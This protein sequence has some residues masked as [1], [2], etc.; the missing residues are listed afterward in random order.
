MPLRGGER[1]GNPESGNWQDRC[2]QCATGQVVMEEVVLRRRADDQD[3]LSASWL[4][5]PVS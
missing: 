4:N 2:F 5:V 3:E 1:R